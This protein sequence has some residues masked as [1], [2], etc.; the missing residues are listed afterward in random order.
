MAAG[1]KAKSKPQFSFFLKVTARLYLMAMKT[2]LATRRIN[3]RI[4]RSSQ[5]IYRWHP[6]LIDAALASSQGFQTLEDLVAST[7]FQLRCQAIAA[8]YLS[9]RAILSG[10]RVALL[11]PMQTCTEPFLFS[12]LRKACPDLDPSQT[13]LWPHLFEFLRYR[14]LAD[15][16]R[17]LP[18]LV[19]NGRVII[20]WFFNFQ[21]KRLTLFAR[22]EYQR[23][24]RAADRTESLDIVDQPW[25][26]PGEPDCSLEPI[27]EALLP[28]IQS[29]EDA[30]LVWLTVACGAGLAECAEVYGCSLATIQRRVAVVICRFARNY[31][32]DEKRALNVDVTRCRN[33]LASAIPP[34]ALSAWLQERVASLESSFSLSQSCLSAKVPVQQI[35]R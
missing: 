21:R 31:V 7:E 10:S 30:C 3:T 8:R 25:R 28:S 32:G 11:D 33:E 23:L 12:T 13:F 22:A 2:Q 34:E 6:A 14:Y 20:Y 5:A 16:N 1:S 29:R 19:E 18:G 26:E 17:F 27:R 4:L 9:L 35:R 24:R 15:V